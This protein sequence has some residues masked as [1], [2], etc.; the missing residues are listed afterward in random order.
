MSRATLTI[1]YDGEAL[2][3]GVMDVRDL[4]PALLAVGQLFD[5]ANIALNGTEAE[6]KVQVRATGA[7]CFSIDLQVVQSLVH[8]VTH[9]F[10]GEE[11]TSAANLM[12]IIFGLGT[13]AG[14]VFGLIRALGGKNPKKIEKLDAGMAR[15]TTESGNSLNVP[16]AE[17][18]L[19]S[20]IA[21]RVAIERVVAEPLAKP[22]IDRFEVRDETGDVTSVAKDEG[23]HFA[24]PDVP[25]ETITEDVRRAA[26]S[27]ISLAFKEDNKWRLSDGASQ[28]SARIA[29]EA[30]LDRVESNQIAFAKGDIL[31]CEVRVTATQTPAGLKTDYV[32]ERVVEHRPAMRQLRLFDDPPSVPQS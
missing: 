24:R 26:Y 13:L 17:I 9:I 6:I 21:M 14:G 18:R 1:T 28:I 22:G 27:I 15:V 23:V 8:K 5:A 16:L 20:D 29:D 10:A 25:D 11:A 12:T 31:I 19:Y 30:F 4:A 2:R 32:V 3:D 7:A